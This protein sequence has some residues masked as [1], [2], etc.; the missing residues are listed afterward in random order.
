MAG[1]R[2][3]DGSINNGTELFSNAMPQPGH[4]AQW[5]GFGALALYDTPQYGGNGDGVIDAEDGIYRKLLVWV[6]SNHNGIS[7][8]G[9]LIPLQQ[10]G[11]KAISLNYHD[12]HYTDAYGNQ[13]RYRAEVQW[14]S[15][16]TD[17]ILAT[18]RKRIR[19]RARQNWR[20]ANAPSQTSRGSGDQ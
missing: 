18:L 14:Y 11:I 8:P 13:F 17:D 5:L 9:E 19:S 3:H 4:P 10:A 15:E 16:V 6:D 2:N 7:D 12:A 1:P 20:Y